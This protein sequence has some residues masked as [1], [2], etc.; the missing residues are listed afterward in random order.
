MKR[1]ATAYWEGG[2]KNGQGKISSE[3][4]VLRDVPYSFAK[5][6]GEERGTNPEELIGAAHSG[7]FAMA[8]S[9][10][11]E[12]LNLRADSINVKAEVT[13]DKEGEGFS[14]SDVHLDV[15]A[16]VPNATTDQIQRAANLAKENCPVSKL[17]NANITMNLQLPENTYQPTM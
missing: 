7:C 5:R 12:K 2:I 14:I 10:E 9:L 15:N 1:S 3:S 6:F 11:L 4:G 17:I 16:N 8:F 13:I